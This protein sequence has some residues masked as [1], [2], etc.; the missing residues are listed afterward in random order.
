MAEISRELSKWPT[1]ER[2]DGLL[3]ELRELDQ[4]DARVQ[5]A[6]NHLLDYRNT[7]T[8]RGSDG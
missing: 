1:L 8:G 4:H 2:T 5:N 6:I 3:R 7:I